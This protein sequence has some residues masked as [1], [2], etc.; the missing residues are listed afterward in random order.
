MLNHTYSYNRNINTPL[1]GTYDYT[2]ELMNKKHSIG[3]AKEDIKIKDT[4][5]DK[6]MQTRTE[7]YKT[8]RVSILIITIMAKKFI[9]RVSLL[10]GQPIA[11]WLT[12]QG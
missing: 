8:L 10:L 4:G 3:V 7:L 6:N 12:T 9:A 5:W 2:T 1:T 11:M